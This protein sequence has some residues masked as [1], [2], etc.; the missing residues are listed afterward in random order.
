MW[1]D[2]VHITLNLFNGMGT[3]SDM[4]IDCVHIT[5]QLVFHLL[6]SCVV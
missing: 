1:S 6:L 2:C 4:W 5:G 3:H